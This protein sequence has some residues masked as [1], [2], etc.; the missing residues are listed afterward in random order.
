MERQTGNP[1][2]V[3]R[4]ADFGFPMLLLAAALFSNS[5]SLIGLSIAGLTLAS[6]E[7]LTVF[8]P[9]RLSGALSQ[10]FQY[11]LGKALQ[12]GNLFIALC[13]VSAGFWLA[14]EAFDLTVSGSGFSEIFPLGLALAATTNVLVVIWHGVLA[15]AQVAPFDQAKRVLLRPRRR[16]FALLVTFQLVLTIAVLA[17]DADIAHWVDTLGAAVVALI[18]V[19]AGSKL[20]W[21]CVCDLIDHPLGKE[22]EAAITTLLYRE[23]VQPEELV[24]LRTRRC[25]QQIFAEVTLHMMEA[26]PVEEARQRLTGLRRALETTV[27][28]LDLVIKLQGSKR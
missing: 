4:I 26:M 19:G 13:A 27:R 17:K 1:D 28:D 5:L 7:A 22:Q 18:I 12:A 20:A 10:H 14:G 23:G 16:L 21:D 15:Y 9:R 25:G 8:L 6:R 24:D 11:G 2:T 3:M